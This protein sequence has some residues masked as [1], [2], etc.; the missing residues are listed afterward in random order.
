M[1]FDAHKLA[2]LGLLMTLKTVVAWGQPAT[3]APDSMCP[4]GVKPSVSP[5]EMLTQT[6]F[7]R[8]QTKNFTYQA[9]A[10]MV[11]RMPSPGHYQLTYEINAF[12]FLN[13][14]QFSEG[15]WSEGGPVPTRFVEQSKKKWVTL[16]NPDQGLVK[17]SDPLR[18]SPM[19]AGS[20][21]KLSIW[22]RLGWWIMCHPMDLRQGAQVHVPVWGSGETE[23]WTL[24]SNGLVSIRTPY[25]D[26]QALH[27]TRPAQKGGDSQI[28][29]W[30]VPEWGVLPVR[31]NVK[32]ANGDLADQQLKERQ[33]RP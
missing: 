4:N 16:A 10:T 21:D 5:H 14:Q 15:R 33:P 24:T 26:K 20:Q 32:Q 19:I 7:V 30:F 11:W 28:D 6:Y 23:D 8:G 22:A 12:G 1:P 9:S 25:G 13:R 31:I 2:F 3:H 29:L 27:I 18:E 17:F